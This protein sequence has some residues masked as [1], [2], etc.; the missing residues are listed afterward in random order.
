M[1]KRPRRFRLWKSTQDRL[2]HAARQAQK[3]AYC[4]YS[5]YPVGAAVLTASGRIFAGCNVENAS[6]GLSLCAERAAVGT[7]V[8]HGQKGIRAIAVVAR[9]ARPCGACRQVLLEFAGPDAE[10]LMVHIDPIRKRQK[11]SRMRVARSMPN[12]FDPQE[13]GL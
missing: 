3:M 10:I 1:R 8:S 13:A 4:P 5:R 11:V 6:F 7:A 9:S 12:R 2:I